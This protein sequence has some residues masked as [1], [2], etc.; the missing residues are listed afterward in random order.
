[1]AMKEWVETIEWK[2]ALTVGRAAVFGTYFVVYL[3]SV[4]FY[5]PSHSPLSKSMHLVPLLLNHPLKV[6]GVFCG[7]YNREETLE[8]A[9]ELYQL[10]LIS[11]RPLLT[12]R[13]ANGGGEGERLP[14]P[15]R[16]KSAGAREYTGGKVVGAEAEERR[17]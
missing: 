7:T 16:F 13:P 12:M 10:L 1:M 5:S 17:A 3:Y 11:Q 6:S 15:A 4:S 2:R 8:G 14:C 9:Q